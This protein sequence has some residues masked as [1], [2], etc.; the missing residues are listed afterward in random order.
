MCVLVHSGCFKQNITD[1]VAYKQQNLFTVLEAVIMVM[2]S[3]DLLSRENLLLG[4]QTA[5]SGCV[6]TWWK[7]RGLSGVSSI[8]ALIP[9]M[10]GSALLTY[11]LTKDPTLPNI[12]TLEV[13]ISPWEFGGVGDTNV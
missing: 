2:V 10:R 12:I 6:L 1:W 11:S 7:G 8:K 13:K 5:A 4:S 3:A 9:L